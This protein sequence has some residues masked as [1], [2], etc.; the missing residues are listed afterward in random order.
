MDRFGWATIDVE[1]DHY[2]ATDFRPILRRT[3]GDL[4][5]DH[6]YHDGSGFW[7]EVDSTNLSRRGDVGSLGSFGKYWWGSNVEGLEN[8]QPREQQRFFWN[9]FGICFFD[10]LPAGHFYTLWP[11]KTK[12]YRPGRAVDWD[13]TALVGRKYADYMRQ[14]LC[15]VD[16]IVLCRIERPCFTPKLEAWRDIEVF[17]P[18]GGFGDPVVDF[19][20]LE[21]ATYDPAFMRASRWQ[22]MITEAEIGEI[23]NR[24]TD[25]IA[26]SVRA[27]FMDLFRQKS[28]LGGQ[29]KITKAKAAKKFAVL[30]EIWKSM[31]VSVEDSHLDQVA[32][33][34]LEIAEPGHVRDILGNWEDRTI[35]I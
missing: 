26:R 35:S 2:S 10:R 8:F 27:V 24:G 30:H 14:N 9:A 17:T 3:G 7:V 20:A 4:L 25:P 23:D 13:E 18:L 12:N 5:E 29:E 21:R 6:V 1:L 19:A 15:V 32:G 34:L 33:L 28:W 11:S 16:D 31:G 22:W